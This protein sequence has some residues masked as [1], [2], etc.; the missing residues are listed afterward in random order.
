MIYYCYWADLV[1]M[2]ELTFIFVMLFLRPKLL[3]YVEVIADAEVEPLI[4]GR[5]VLVVDDDCF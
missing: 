4:S 1:D 2:M 5:F 3:L